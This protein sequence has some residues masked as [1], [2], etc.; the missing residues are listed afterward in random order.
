MALVESTMLPL[1]TTLPS[2]SLIN[3]MDNKMVT[4]KQYQHQPLLIA[5]IC[6]HCPYV[7]HILEKFTEQLNAY[8]QQGVQSICIS[9]NDIATYPADSP[10]KMALLAKQYQFNFPYCYDE[11]QQVAK[12]FQAQCTPDLFLFDATHQLYYRGRFDSSTP[13]NNQPVTGI[14]CQQ[15]V[16]SL[17]EDN[18]RPATQHPSMGCS[19]KWKD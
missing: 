4:H 11:S 1:G 13:G 14:D 17:L 16:Q 18:P 12:A 7:V 3:T 8:Q 6:N 15:A 2:F 10:D 19:I 5:F 9:S